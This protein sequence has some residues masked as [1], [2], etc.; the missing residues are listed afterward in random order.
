MHLFISNQEFAKAVEPRMR[1]LDN[2]APSGVAF[3]LSVLLAARTN[4]GEI[5]ATANRLCSGC[6][7]KAGIGTPM[8][9]GART[10]ARAATDNGIQHGS[11]L[12][13]IMMMGCG[14]DDR[15]RDATCVDQQLPLAPIFSPNPRGFARQIL[16]PAGLSAEPRRRFASA[17]RCLP[18][19]RTWPTPLAKRHGSIPRTPIPRS[20]CELH[21]RCRSALWAVPSGVARV[22]RTDFRVR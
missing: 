1:D 4:V 19:R 6:A 20:V 17:R 3:L 16:A 12:H 18:R 22:G 10:V 7:A 8:L 15:Q 5:P 11:E 21:W 2:P 9:L 13:D 14:H